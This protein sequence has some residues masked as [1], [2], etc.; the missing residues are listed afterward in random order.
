MKHGTHAVQRYA[1]S[2]TTAFRDF[3]PTCAKQALYV[4]PGNIRLNGV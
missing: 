2:R 4:I 1:Y 3:R